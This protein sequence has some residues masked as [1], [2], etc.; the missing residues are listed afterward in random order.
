MMNALFIIRFTGQ[1][2]PILMFSRS[3]PELTFCYSSLAQSCHEFEVIRI[4]M[5]YSL[6]QKAV[7][8]SFLQFSLELGQK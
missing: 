2:L 5:G 3:Y 6:S 7:Y 1:P 4:C 8:Q